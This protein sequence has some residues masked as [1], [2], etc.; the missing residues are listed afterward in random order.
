[1][2]NLSKFSMNNLK[3]DKKTWR[4]INIYYIHYFDKNKTENW[5]VTSVNP[6]YLIIN[7]VFCFVGE[8]N[9]VKYLK[10]DKRDKKL[11]DS[12]WKLLE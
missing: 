8:E 6:L 9:A 11:E 10:I 1:M 7:K 5:C 4:D 3:L 12:I 2:I